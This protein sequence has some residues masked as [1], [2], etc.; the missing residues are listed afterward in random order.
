[1]RRRREPCEIAFAGVLDTFYTADE[2][3]KAAATGEEPPW[4]GDDRLNAL[5]AAVADYLAHKH[6]LGRP[7]WTRDPYRIL[8][9]P[10]FA[11]AIAEPGINQYLWHVSPA[12]LRCRNIFTDERPLR[13][14]PQ[15][16]G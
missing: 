1:M 4:S 16:A 14:A 9:Q 8:R 7:S 6:R 2:A 3:G 5:A 13:R 10:W 15:R 12:E 11:T